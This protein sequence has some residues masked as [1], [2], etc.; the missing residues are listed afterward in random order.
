MV[1][2]TKSG[3]HESSFTRAA[4]IALKKLQGETSS[5]SSSLGGIDDNDEDDMDAADDEF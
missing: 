4:M 1:N 2:F 3:N 5:L